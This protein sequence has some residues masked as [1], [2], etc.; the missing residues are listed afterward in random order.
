VSERAVK[1]GTQT[2]TPDGFKVEVLEGLRAGERVA[3]APTGTT[4]FDGAEITAEA[5]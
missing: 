5:R 1:P 4:L 3:V 2:E